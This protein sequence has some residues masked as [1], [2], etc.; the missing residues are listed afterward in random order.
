MSYKK[1]VY[2]SY[3]G[4][5]QRQLRRK[6]NGSYDVG[7][8]YARAACDGATT[9]SAPKLG[10]VCAG[11]GRSR[12]RL[13]KFS[14]NVEFCQGQSTPRLKLRRKTNFLNLRKFDKVGRR[15]KQRKLPPCQ[16]FTSHK[17]VSKNC[18][19]RRIFPLIYVRKK[20]RIYNH[21]R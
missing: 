2:G 18:S 16:I 12:R 8:T 5:P 13:V 15:T 6:Q 20:R 9:K 14:K 11:A 10:S 4:R 17:I 21:V 7:R 19:H 1:L 3:E